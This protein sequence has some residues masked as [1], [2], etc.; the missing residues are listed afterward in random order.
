MVVHST[1]FSG[2]G[3]T[4]TLTGILSKARFLS[5]GRI[6]TMDYK[7]RARLPS[8]PSVLI[9]LG[10]IAFAATGRSG[11]AQAISVAESL[12]AE[13]R[14]AAEKALP[15]IVTIRR[16]GSIL[17]EQTT[18]SGLTEAREPRRSFSV[19]GSGIIINGDRGLI[20]TNDHVIANGDTFE[21]I[22][23]D[24]RRR[25]VLE[26]RRDPR[27]D[28]AL[29]VIDPTGLD[30]QAITWGDSA[31]IETGD[32][33]LSLGQ[34]FGL[35][36]TVS[37]GI[38]SGT[39]R[40]LSLWPHRDL[41]QTDAAINP[42]SSGGAL[43]DLDG[44]LVGVNVAVQ[45]VSGGFEGVGFA[46]PESRARRVSDDLSAIGQVR[47]VSIGVRL[48]TLD[49]EMAATLQIPGGV[50]VSSVLE[51]GPADRGGVLV[52]DYIIKVDSVPI[53]APDQLISAIEFRD[54][55]QSVV[56]SIVRSNR[57]VDV[58]VKPEPMIAPQSSSKN[59]VVDSDSDQL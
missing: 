38:I 2:Q 28:L 25:S 37:A 11:S 12:S 15:S 3:S 34:P 55:G 1:E 24:R 40:T 4:S 7:T 14:R 41:L 29:L 21:V 8:R 9:V 49:P 42:G 43:V 50:L 5:I 20:L 19:G 13:F 47:R 31:S 17:L 58:R 23:A 27:S 46:V 10:L 59:S 32:W 36:G 45:T 6:P 16:A 56:L 39:G 33:V 51:G 22:L 18:Q 57:I 53:A 48:Q 54:P 26:V 44:A 52:E 30:L 35:A